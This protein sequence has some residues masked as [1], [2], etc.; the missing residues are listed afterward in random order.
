MPQKCKVFGQKLTTD[1]TPT[2]TSEMGV[3]GTLAVPIDYYV[4]ADEDNDIYITRISFILGYGTSAQ[5]W[6]FADANTVLVNGVQ[7]FYEDTEG[8]Q[9]TIINPKNNYSFHRASN[10]PISTTAWEA[11][12]FWAAGDFGY[13]VNVSLKDIMPPYGIKLDRGTNQRLT[14]RI[15]DNCSDA[16]LFNCRAFGFERFE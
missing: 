11:R 12:G 3:T 5:G 8:N 7:V 15:R 9:I 10:S 13:F 2:G 4:E 6:E 16:D 1:G 14:V